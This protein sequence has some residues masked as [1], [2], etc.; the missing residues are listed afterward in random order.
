MRNVV[1]VVCRNAL[2][3]FLLV[4]RNALTAFLLRPSI[5]SERHKNTRY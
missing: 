4:Y 3:A 1:L 5:R 2:T